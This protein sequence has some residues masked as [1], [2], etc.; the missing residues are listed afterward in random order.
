MG[1]NIL[2][3]RIKEILME[4]GMSQAELARRTGVSVSSMQNVFCG[5]NHF[6][7]NTLI[8][9]A[10]ILEVEFA[11]LFERTGWCKK[12]EKE[13]SVVADTPR[14]PR[15]DLS[16]IDVYEI[17]REMGWSS[18]KTCTVFIG[19]TAIDASC[20]RQLSDASGIDYDKLTTIVKVK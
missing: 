10:E 9:M 16:S 8:K 13:Q 5:A 2:K 14:R 15:F 4:R 12:P 18:A 17:S 7:I 11:D 19:K 20:L 3:Y 1:N 6:R